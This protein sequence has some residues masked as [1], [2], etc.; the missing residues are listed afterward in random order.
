ASALVVAVILILTLLFAYMNWWDDIF[1]AVGNLAIHMNL[2]FYVFFST[3]MFLIWA[4]TVFIFDRMRYWVFIP[5]QMQ[6][7]RIW[8]GAER[9]FD[10]RGMS[11]YKR[12]D[13]LFRHWVLGMGS[14]DLHITT[15][16]AD[17]RE[18]DVMN[19]MFIGSKIDTIQKL[20]AMRPD[21]MQDMHTIT[22]GRPE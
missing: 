17:S 7:M 4:A 21:E 19:V 15:V 3:A 20:V 12:R 18:F 2:G 6:Y 1:E 13:D 14:G 8:G 16:G 22:A 9:T 5:G 10:T 11:V